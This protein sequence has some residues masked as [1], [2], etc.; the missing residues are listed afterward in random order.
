MGL[1][2]FCERPLRAHSPPPDLPT[3]G[4]NA[5]GCEPERAC[6]GDPGVW[7]PRSRCQPADLRET[8]FRVHTAARPV[9]LRDKSW[10]R[11]RQASLGSACMR[12]LLRRPSSDP[13]GPHPARLLCPWGSPGKNTA[14]GCHFL[15][16]GNLPDPGIQPESPVSPVLAGRFLTAEPTGKSHWV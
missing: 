2:P 4:H 9:G 15:L 1:A 14:V 10:S 11:G 13:H 3:S 6:S 7:V 8:D 5:G 16:Q 12:A